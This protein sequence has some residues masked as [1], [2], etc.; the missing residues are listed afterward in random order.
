[1]D[2]YVNIYIYKYKSPKMAIPILSGNSIGHGIEVEQFAV[3][4]VLGQMR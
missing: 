3:E 1:M 4:K 2:I